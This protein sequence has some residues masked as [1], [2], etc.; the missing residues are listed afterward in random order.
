MSKTGL[1]MRNASQCSTMSLLDF[2]SACYCRIGGPTLSMPT[3]GM[4]AYCRRSWPEPPAKGLRQCSRCTTSPFRV[5]F[6]LASIPS[7]AFLATALSR[8]AEFYGKISFLKP[9]SAIAIVLQREP[10][11]AR[12]ILTAEYGCGLEGLL[13]RRA[14][15]LV[16]I[17]NGADY[18]IWDPQPTP[19]SPPT[20]ICKTS[21]ASGYARR[22]CKRNSV[23]KWM[24]RLRSSF[25]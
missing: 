1:T 11:Y 23:L 8:R 24:R 10:T 13:Q 4:P 25:L 3:I 6:P 9:A 22:R 14:K 18:R 16:G 17:L 20:S 2:R 19:I 21:P 15:D 7:S 5:C 12:E